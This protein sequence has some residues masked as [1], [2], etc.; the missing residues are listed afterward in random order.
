M[1]KAITVSDFKSGHER[2]S[3][4]T[5]SF[6][7]RVANHLYSLLGSYKTY[8]NDK[9]L[10]HVALKLAWYM[11]DIV[12]DMGLWR[13]FSS[14]CQ[15]RW[16]FDVPL[17]HIDE[18]YYPDEP[19]LNAVSYLI[20][21][22]VA[23]ED[24]ENVPY[25]GYAP[26]N[27][28]A[29][30]AY[31]Y[32]YSIFET[33]PINEGRHNFIR[34]YVTSAREGYNKARELLK[35][36]NRYDYIVHSSQFD[37]DIKAAKAEFRRFTHNNSDEGMAN[38]YA[39]TSK[40]FH[41]RCGPLAMHTYEWAASLASIFGMHDLEQLFNSLE[42]NR[43]VLYH[44]D[45]KGGETVHLV[46]INNKEIDVNVEELNL[47]HGSIGTYDT[48][49]AE[50]VRFGGEWRLN[51]II[52]PQKMGRNY[53]DYKREYGNNPPEGSTY[54][55]AAMYR[56]RA[57]EKDVLYFKDTDQMVEFLLS[58]YMATPQLATEMH[59]KGNHK[60]PVV[61]FEDEQGKGMIKISVNTA[62]LIKDPDNP[63]YDVKKAKEDAV[64]ILW[65][66]NVSP[67]LANYLIDKGFLPDA[68]ESDLFLP[69]S[70]S[71][72]LR[73]DMHFIVLTERRNKI[74]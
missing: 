10:R 45:Y 72:Q 1:N 65:D 28:M 21:D 67:G 31:S 62:P 34:D 37:D 43:P 57:G 54:I 24:P 27:D 64:T 15:Q 42:P 23:E 14:L 44:Y 22:V 4:P 46:S 55:S 16:Q 48:L 40:L 17:F 11:E 50:F 61:F 32:L 12:A 19:S 38:Y 70:T 3:Y 56:E 59:S 49:L 6:Y 35:W 53:D 47:S 68:A 73:G 52:I 20:W 41:Y 9:I 51:G 30:L 5:D 66:N 39:V 69:K 7:T 74:P 58:H 36:I 71:D 26:L 13:S 60:W 25:A 18:D 33:C 29:F 8:F 63:Y 2:I